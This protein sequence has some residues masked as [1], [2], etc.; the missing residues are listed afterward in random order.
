MMPRHREGEDAAAG[1]HA[2]GG[3]RRRLQLFLLQVDPEPLE[4]ER[5][6]LAGAR[7]VVRDEAQA[8]PG[9][10]QRL[11]RLGRARHGL[12]GDLEH[13]LD[14]KQILRPWTASLF[15]SRAR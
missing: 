5:E 11:D 15:G 12:P 4:L 9:F 8:V 7:R 13:T 6:V 14:V 2:R 3:E 1:E 10:A